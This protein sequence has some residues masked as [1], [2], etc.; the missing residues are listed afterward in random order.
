MGFST[1]RLSK[2]PLK[3]VISIK[4]KSCNSKLDYK[5]ATASSF[6]EEP[7]FL[8]EKSAV[9]ILPTPNNIMSMSVPYHPYNCCLICGS[10]SSTDQDLRSDIERYNI[11]DIISYHYITFSRIL[12]FFI[13]FFNG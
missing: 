8:E 6:F 3:A 7:L 10:S 5:V 13:S 1:R 9:V 11:I 2:K 4:K 12:I